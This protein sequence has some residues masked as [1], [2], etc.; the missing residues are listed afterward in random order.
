MEC[1]SVPE[2]SRVRFVLPLE[3][4]EYNKTLYAV[5][6]VDWR[7]WNDGKLFVFNKKK[8]W[9]RQNLH[10]SIKKK[11]YRIKCIPL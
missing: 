1:L 9:E 7:D 5:K 2:N 8:A 3:I 6:Q 11:S 10:F 4:C